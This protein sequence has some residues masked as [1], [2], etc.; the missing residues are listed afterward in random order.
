MFAEAHE[1][2]K[3]CRAALS[4]GFDVINLESDA[5]IARRYLADTVALLNCSPQW[6]RDVPPH[7]SNRL[8]VYA[9]NNEQL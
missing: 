5:Q 7:V 3:A 2:L 4:E 9:I 6:C 1:I 8:D